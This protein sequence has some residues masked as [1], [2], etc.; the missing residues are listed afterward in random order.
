MIEGFSGYEKIAKNL[1]G[2][3]ANDFQFLDKLDWVVTEKI[4]G[5]NFSF[6]YENRALKFA[7]R[8]ELLTWK[9][10]FF[11]FQLVVAQIESKILAF[12]EE[13]S[14]HHKATKYIIYGEL[15]GGV[16][17]HNEV[18]PDKRVNAIQTGVYYA[19]SINFLAFDIA[20]VSD[21]KYY[22]P[23]KESV[24]HFK[25][26]NLLYVKPLFIGKLSEA[27]NFDISIDSRI[28]QELNLPNIPDNLV[29]GVVVKPYNQKTSA[30]KRPIIKIKNSKFDEEKK[31]HLAKKWT[32]IP[33]TTSNTEELSFLISDLR[34]YITKNRLDSA[35]S[36][37]GAVDNTNKERIS[38]LED[39]FLE[40]VFLDFNLENDQIL[41]EI[42]EEEKKWIRERIHADIRQFIL[43]FYKE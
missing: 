8:K 21:S 3:D 32:F 22:L 36:K 40:D 10:D 37:I 23:Y 2:F 35:I 19:P 7:K 31:F 16:Y 30:D 39:E 28:P 27:L 41:D 9:S 5:A 34:N 29:E 17:P 42:D 25:K 15:F 4:H 20:I 24:M 38:E 43:G 18:I 26:H 11:G 12:F 6:I 13:L 33:D 14:L 1:K